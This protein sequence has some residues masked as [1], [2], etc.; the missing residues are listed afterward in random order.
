MCQVLDMRPNAAHSP[1]R[2]DVVTIPEL[3]S[4]GHRPSWAIPVKKR[5]GQVYDCSNRLFHKMGGSKTV[6]DYH[7]QGGNKII[8]ETCC[9]Q[10]W[11]LKKYSDGQR[12]P[13]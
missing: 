13:I 5:W 1:K 11:S 12:L 3:C 6:G 7:Q 9:L 10:I 8:V 2:I 4:M